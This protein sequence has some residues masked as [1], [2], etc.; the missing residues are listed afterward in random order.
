MS[1][2]RSVKKEA[3]MGHGEAL[4]DLTGGV[5]Q[6]ILFPALLFFLSMKWAPAERAATKSYEDFETFYPFYLSQ[7]QVCA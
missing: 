6:N 1:P 4:A 2:P 3:E 5:G 7:H